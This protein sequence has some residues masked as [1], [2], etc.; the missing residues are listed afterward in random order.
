[1]RPALVEIRVPPALERAIQGLVFWIAAGGLAWFLLNSAPD[2]PPDHYW[3]VLAMPAACAFWGAVFLIDAA[4]H[5]RRSPQP[6]RRRRS[7][8][9]IM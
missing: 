1:M 4:Q 2:H 7:R 3:A 8:H 9:P 6:R 5:R